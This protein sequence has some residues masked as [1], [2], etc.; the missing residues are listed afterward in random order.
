MLYGVV[1]TGAFA[2]VLF[3]VAV[4]V[5]DK[6][7]AV[8][9]RPPGKPVMVHVKTFADDVLHVLFSAEAS[10]PVMSVVLAGAFHETTMEP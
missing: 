1:A 10:Y 5:S 7:P 9:G 8:M 2:S 3:T 4:A 6:T